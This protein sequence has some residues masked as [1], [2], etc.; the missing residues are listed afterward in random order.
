[1]S[2]LKIEETRDN[3]LLKRKE[4]RYKVLFGNESTPK[5]EQIRDLLAKNLGV[6]KELIIV[7]NNVQQS[8]KHEMNGYSKVYSDKESAM[9]YEPDY[10]L[11][12]NGLKIKEEAEAE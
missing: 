3:K 4:I 12:R 6:N 5:R 7:D 11:Y 8:G 10:E 1:M 9:L 2:E